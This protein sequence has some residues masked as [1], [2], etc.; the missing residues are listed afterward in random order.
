MPDFDDMVV[1]TVQFLQSWS[2]CTGGVRQKPKEA[3]SDWG[4]DVTSDRWV[5]GR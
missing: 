3:V 5:W 1:N 4:A 2:I